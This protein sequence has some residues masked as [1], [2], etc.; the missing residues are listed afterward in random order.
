MFASTMSNAMET[1]GATTQECACR[2]NKNS[3]LTA[4][5]KQASTSQMTRYA[6]SGSTAIQKL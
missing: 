5:E 2:P 4:M 6:L 1:A 3:E